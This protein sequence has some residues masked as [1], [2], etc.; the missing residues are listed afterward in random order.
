MKA[1]ALCKITSWNVSPPPFCN[2]Y[3]VKNKLTLTF[4]YVDYMC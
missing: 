4:K 1:E 2:W 3:N